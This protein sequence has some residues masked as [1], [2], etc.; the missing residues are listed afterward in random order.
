[1]NFFNE[2]ADNNY[3]L[4]NTIRKLQI[5]LRNIDTDLIEHWIEG[6]LNGYK[7]DDSLPEYRYYKTESM[8]MNGVD[9]T[10]I[11][12]LK[13]TNYPIT[14]NGYFD[15]KDLKKLS[16]YPIP[17]S[18]QELE[19]FLKADNIKIATNRY[20]ATKL[21][22]KLR[23]EHPDINIFN[24]CTGITTVDIDGILNK[25][26][27][28]LLNFVISIHKEFPDINFDELEPLD[29]KNREF[30][31]QNFSNISNSNISIDSPETQQKV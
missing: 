21:E 17:N 4:S 14:L 31:I 22:I 28:K 30:V 23:E 29:N 25:I 7:A 2:I 15:K 11:N 1:M 3:P 9:G 10:S 18:I 6:E 13:Y 12:G 16:N 20:Y 27:N 19:H 26:R 8:L 5:I 24:L